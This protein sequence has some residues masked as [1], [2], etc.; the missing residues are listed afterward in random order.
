MADSFVVTVPYS[1]RFRAGHAHLAAFLRASSTFLR[2][3]TTES[4]M[5]RMLFTNLR[6]LIAHVCA[7]RTQFL[8]ERRNTA[9][10]STGQN[11]NVAT[12]P[13]QPNAPLH[14]LRIALMLHPDHVVATFLAYLRAAKTSG[15]ALFPFLRQRSFILMHGIAP[16]LVN[17][18]IG[19]ICRFRDVQLTSITRSENQRIKPDASFAYAMLL[20]SPFIILLR[21]S[22]SQSAY[23]RVDTLD[24]SQSARDR[25]DVSAQFVSPS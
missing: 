7:Q 20:T 9:H 24:S 5:R 3:R 2:T 10:P 1:R 19:V 21:S 12:F 6:T 18:L 16:S 11:A 4:M 14:Q 8:G 17:V 25:A 13:A 22:A 23:D 15:N